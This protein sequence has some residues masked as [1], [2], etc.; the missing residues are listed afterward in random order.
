MWPY[1]RSSM[2]AESDGASGGAGLEELWINYHADRGTMRSDVRV[3]RDGTGTWQV[4]HGSNF[5]MPREPGFM[6]VWAVVRDNRGGV[7]WIS[8][9]LYVR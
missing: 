1:L 3:L 8:S 2:N 4:N 5:Y 9:L 6:R 7:D